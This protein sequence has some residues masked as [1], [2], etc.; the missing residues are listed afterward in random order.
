[1]IYCPLS[2]SCRC[3]ITL[4][5]YSIPV[6]LFVHSLY[7]H[8]TKFNYTH[9]QLTLEPPPLSSTHPNPHLTQTSSYPT[10]KYPGDAQSLTPTSKNA[11]HHN[12]QPQIHN[13][14]P[15][16]YTSTTFQ[17]YSPP[18]PPSP[19]A[20]ALVPALSTPKSNILKSRHS[21]R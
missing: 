6:Y 2:R 20:A 8:T 21:H 3:S 9:S 14:R 11:T 12:M 1:M 16:L 18:H 4:F 7:T 17:S 19:A 15:L 5:Y 10:Y 13:P